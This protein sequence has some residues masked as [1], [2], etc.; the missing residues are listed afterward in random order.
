[1]EYPVDGAAV[2]VKDL[3]MRLVQGALNDC[4]IPITTAGALVISSD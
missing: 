4:I 3:F 1:M 2:K